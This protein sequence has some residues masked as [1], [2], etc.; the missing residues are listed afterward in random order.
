[1][2]VEERDFNVSFDSGTDFDLGFNQSVSFG[3]GFGETELVHTSDHRELTHRDANDQHPMSAIT[4]L[5][6]ALDAKQDALASGVSIKTVNG[7]SVLGSGDIET[8]NA[9]IN[10]E[11]SLVLFYGANVV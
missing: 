2:L 10:G 6:A 11:G 5:G 4:G 8:L 9:A 1:M 3:A 7:E